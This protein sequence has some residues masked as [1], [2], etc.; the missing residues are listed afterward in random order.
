MKK[1]L[2]EAIERLESCIRDERAMLEDGGCNKTFVNGVIVGYLNS[3]DMLKHM[4]NTIKE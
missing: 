2:E 4:L 1:I 3:R